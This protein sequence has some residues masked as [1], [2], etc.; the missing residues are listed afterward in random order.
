[1]RR[2]K[3][4]GI[5]RQQVRVLL[6]SPRVNGLLVPADES[7]EVRADSWGGCSLAGRILF[8]PSCVFLFFSLTLKD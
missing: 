5:V 8:L 7:W 2:A 4:D 6:P 1:V 3:A